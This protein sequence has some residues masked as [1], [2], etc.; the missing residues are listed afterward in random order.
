[1]HFIFACSDCSLLVRDTVAVVAEVPAVIA[2]TCYGLEDR[3][4]AEYQY[5]T[6]ALV[7]FAE[8]EAANLTQ[9]VVEGELLHYHQVQAGVVILEVG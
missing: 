7:L 8:V 2:G 9:A 5:H 4:V 1:M 6:E 3:V